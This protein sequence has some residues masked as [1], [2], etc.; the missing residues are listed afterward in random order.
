MRHRNIA[1]IWRAGI[2]LII[3]ALAVTALQIIRRAQVDWTA[4]L[5]GSSQHARI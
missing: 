2:T 1:V 4:D 3:A 5:A